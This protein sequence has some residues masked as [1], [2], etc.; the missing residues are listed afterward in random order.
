[1]SDLPKFVW[2]VSDCLPN[3][4]RAESRPHGH[5][6]DVDGVGTTLKKGSD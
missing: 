1:M 4:Q 2:V 6:L 5:S 3:F